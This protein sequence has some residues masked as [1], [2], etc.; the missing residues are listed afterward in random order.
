MITVD[1]GDALTELDGFRRQVS[2]VFEKHG[3]VLFRGI[4][5]LDSGR[6]VRLLQTD[7]AR[8]QSLLEAFRRKWDTRQ[9]SQKLKRKR[10]H[11]QELTPPAGFNIV[12]AED[13]YKGKISVGDRSKLRFLFPENGQW[14]ARN[15][16]K[17]LCEI[18][19]PDFEANGEIRDAQ[20]LA[21]LP[22]LLAVQGPHVDAAPTNSS[23]VICE[24]NVHSY[25]SGDPRHPKSLWLVL[26]P[27][28]IYVF[29]GMHKPGLS[30]LE[31][32]LANYD[33][34]MSEWLAE[35]EDA[36]ESE[37]AY[38]WVEGMKRRMKE[39]YPGEPPVEAVMLTVNG[40]DEGLLFS[41][42]LPHGGSMR[43]GVRFFCTCV[44]KA[45]THPT[46]HA[47]NSFRDFCSLAGYADVVFCAGLPVRG[48]LDLPH[49][50][51]RVPTGAV[52]HC[53]EATGI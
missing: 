45:V 16:F 47:L 22:S 14:E 7:E 48:Q 37:F 42:I 5:N 50:V 11:C 10:K 17:A 43:P 1:L 44:G 4:K 2:D 46:M 53:D 23:G 21:Q 38:V 31:A 25:R 35:N 27:T 36:G 52:R 15:V 29:L 24:A 18:L 41:G 40:P 6:L 20:A 9:T 49:P 26:E 32:A 34:E 3:I 28:D 51:Q 19:I 8:L 39:E 13:E 30:L 12:F 33:V